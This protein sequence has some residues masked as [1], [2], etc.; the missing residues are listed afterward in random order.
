MDYILEY[1]VAKWKLV[2]CPALKTMNTWQCGLWNAPI[3]FTQIPNFLDITKKNPDSTMIVIMRHD[4]NSTQNV[5]NNVDRTKQIYFVATMFTSLLSEQLPKYTHEDTSTT[6]L[7][8]PQ[9]KLKAHQ[10]LFV[11]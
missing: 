9:V 5:I 10:S 7:S 2:G 6:H 11:R 4:R 1:N 3:T 8:H